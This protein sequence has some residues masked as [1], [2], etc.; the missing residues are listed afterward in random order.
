MSNKIT[1]FSIVFLGLLC[2][3]MQASQEPAIDLQYLAQM[4]DQQSMKYRTVQVAKQ[5]VPAALIAS[6]W[7]NGLG[8]LINYDYP[9]GY[10]DFSSGAMQTMETRM[11]AQGICIEFA[12]ICGCDVVKSGC[13]DNPNRAQAQQLRIQQLLAAKYNLGQ[14]NEFAQ[15]NNGLSNSCR[16]MLNNL[17]KKME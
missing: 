2:S 15:V 10:Q 4:Q 17:H 16:T 5:V 3:I 11:K 1:L 6:A 14:M 7:C 9:I 8:L 13:C 12:L